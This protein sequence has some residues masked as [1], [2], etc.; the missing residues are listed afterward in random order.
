MGGTHRGRIL[1]DINFYNIE[2]RYW[3]RI[4]SKYHDHE[5]PARC[6]AAICAFG[7]YIFVFGGHR[8]VNDGVKVNHENLDDFYQVGMVLEVD[9]SN[10]EID[11]W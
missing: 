11:P 6:H 4:E 2:T 9:K 5:M 8:E 7:N 1:N 10:G 3:Q